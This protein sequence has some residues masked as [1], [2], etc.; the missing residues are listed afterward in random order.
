V[1]YNASAPAVRAD[2]A[3]HRRAG[4]G[5]RAAEQRILAALFVLT[6]VALPLTHHQMGPQTAF[7]PVVLSAVLVVDIVSAYLLVSRF[8]DTGDSRLLV[9]AL[10]YVW[11]SI[12]VMGYAMVF[13][14]F[15]SDPSPLSSWPSAPPWLYLAWHVGFP[16]LLAVAWAAP[17]RFMP[18]VAP[19]GRRRVAWRRLTCCAAVSTAVVLF[20]AL[21]GE[22]TMPAIIDGLDSTRMTR[23]AGPPAIALTIVC[24][25]IITG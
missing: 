18:A 3:G 15:V 25:L 11:S 19:A 17:E 5:L 21:L 14:G 22:H 20:V 6:V 10:A 24:A 7:L 23:L 4:S 13:P 2:A 1:T 12:I 8:R 9:M 16:V